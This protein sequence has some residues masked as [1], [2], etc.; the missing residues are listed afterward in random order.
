MIGYLAED[1]TVGVSSPADFAED[2]VLRIFGHAGDMAPLAVAEMGSLA[3]FWMWCHRWCGIHGGQC[4]TDKVTVFML[5]MMWL[6]VL[7]A[8]TLIDWVFP[9]ELCWLDVLE[10]LPGHWLMNSYM[11]DLLA[12]LLMVTRAYFRLLYYVVYVLPALYW[13]YWLLP[14]IIGCSIK[15]NKQSILTNNVTEHVTF[16]A[17]AIFTGNV[18]IW[19]WVIFTSS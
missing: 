6:Y 5:D 1:F 16:M 4:M 9:G 3:I 11:V 18:H 10:W 7:D 17:W 13:L 19:N 14:T 8:G 15:L 12:G 2:V